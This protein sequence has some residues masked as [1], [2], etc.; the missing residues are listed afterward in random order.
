MRGIGQ[1]HAQ[2]AEY[3]QTATTDHNKAN[4][5]EKP[6]QTL[7][8]WRS[9]GEKTGSTAKKYDFVKFYAFMHT[10]NISMVFVLSV[11]PSIAVIFCGFRSH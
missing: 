6:E 8:R 10:Q 11:S 1:A 4:R 5:N 9:T 2:T 7:G 3:V